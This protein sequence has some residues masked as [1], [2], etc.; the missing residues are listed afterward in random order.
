MNRQTLNKPFQRRISFCAPNAKQSA[1]SG[2]EKHITYKLG[3]IM[4]TFLISWLPFSI[5]WPLNSLC[6]A[7]INRRIYIVSFY[8]AYANSIFTPLILLYNNVKYRNSLSIFK[9]SVCRFFC[10]KKS[11]YNRNNLSSYL[12]GNSF[13][14]RK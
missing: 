5:L 10:N 4:F 8:L 3:F 9:N 11:R 7:C 1:Y 6:S 12:D 13:V 14:H 2:R